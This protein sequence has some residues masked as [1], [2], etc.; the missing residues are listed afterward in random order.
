MYL[1]YYTQVIVRLV[2][3]V[4]A[5]IV[6]FIPTLYATARNLNQLPWGLNKVFGCEEDGWN[7]NGIDP[8]NPRQG[9]EEG[10]W[11][12]WV[13]EKDRK[14]GMK[15]QGWDCDHERIKWSELN[16]L[17]RWWRGF[18]WCALR[19]VTWNL[20]L[21]SFAANT[22]YQTIEIVKNITKGK[23]SYIEWKCHKTGKKYFFK[24]KYLFGV[25]W[26]SGWE[27]EPRYFDKTDKLYRRV[28]DHGYTRV[29]KYRKYGIVSIRPRR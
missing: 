29:H 3:F 18:R 14:P 4:V 19:N 13:E 28:R 23:E 25:L 26:E 17:Q 1:R 12:V 9:W 16:F 6:L 21:T 22:H 27:F 15:M 8:N 2:L 5:P 20:R 24:R 7:G 10:N 11:H